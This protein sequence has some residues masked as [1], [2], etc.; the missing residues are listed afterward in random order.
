MEL[1][2]DLMNVGFGTMGGAAASNFYHKTDAPRYRLG[3]SL[4]LGFNALSIL[5]MGSYYLIC[6]HINKTREAEGERDYAELSE[7]QILDMGDKAPTY[8]YT[9]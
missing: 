2:A 6:R 8:R 4:V 5:S 9:L 1:V 7:E 3:H